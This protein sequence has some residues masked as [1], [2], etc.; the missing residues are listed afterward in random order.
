[1]HLSGLTLLAAHLAPGNADELLAA[2]T[3]KSKRVIERLLAERFTKADLP[4]QVRAIPQPSPLLAAPEEGSGQM[5]P[6]VNTE[7]EP[8]P[9]RVDDPIIPS[10]I[11]SPRPAEYA[12]VA[13]LAPQRY[14]IQFTLDQAGHD[15]L[16]QVQDLL[17]HEVP[18]GD[19]AEV[20]VRA[21]KAYAA[22]LEKKKHAATENPRPPRRQKPDSRHVPAH[23]KRVVRKRDKGQC[24][25]VSESG[26]R[27]EARSDLEYDHILE[28]A[29]GGEP[30]A[31]NIRL[32]CRAHNR[33]GAE[34]TYGA[35]FM[36][37][38]L[39][40]ATERRASRHANSGAQAASSP[41]A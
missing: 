8:A 5:Q 9:G 12:R 4:A 17:G 39:A 1:V 36:E 28:Y 13:P 19:L 23:V 35:G 22:L 31:G 32:R 16:R 10:H 24:T 33:L 21:L 14:G 38:K 3:H 15:L 7:S 37:R 25:H 18:R 6:V 34:R 2:A 41:P 29:R 27:C 11:E 26:H 30:T 20:I 40:Q